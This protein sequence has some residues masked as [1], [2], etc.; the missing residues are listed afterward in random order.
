M[1][2]YEFIYRAPRKRT[3]ARMTVRAASVADAQAIY[4]AR[5]PEGARLARVV[6]V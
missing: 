5:K 3:D 2:T 6:E 4:N 1:T